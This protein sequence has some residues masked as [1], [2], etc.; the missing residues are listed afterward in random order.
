MFRV[1]SVA[2][3][4]TGP[5]VPSIPEAAPLLGKRIA[6]VQAPPAA[7]LAGQPKRVRAQEPTTAAAVLLACKAVC[8]LDP[9]VSG[10]DGRAA[11]AAGCGFTSSCSKFSGNGSLL[12]SSMFCQIMPWPAQST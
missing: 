4:V 7:M 2:T 1:Q 12:S 9:V 8:A 6:R 10:K 11:A 5:P 3:P